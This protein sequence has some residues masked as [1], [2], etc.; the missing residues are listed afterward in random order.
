MKVWLRRTSNGW[1]D[2]YLWRIEETSEVAEFD[3]VGLDGSYLKVNL[4]YVWSVTDSAYEI[5]HLK[6]TL[7]SDLTIIR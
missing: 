4:E 6:M 5:V 3:M 7:G 2:F 1:G